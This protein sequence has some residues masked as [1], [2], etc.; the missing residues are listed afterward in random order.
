MHRLAN[1]SG[2]LLIDVLAGS[3]AQTLPNALYMPAGGLPGTFE[4]ANHVQFGLQLL[5]ATNGDTSRPLVFFCQGA[6]C[7]ESYN[8]TL[9]ASALGYSQIYWYR[10][11]L[12][13][14]QE[15]GFPMG[16]LPAVF[17]NAAQ[18]GY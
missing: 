3:H 14:W 12:A 7:W 17:G 2:A 16:P 13:S 4:D 1:E 8:A 10:G 9:R 11:G 5:Q 6:R 15:A 18:N